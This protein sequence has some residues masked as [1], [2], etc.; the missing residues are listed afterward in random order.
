M[1]YFPS[2]HFSP[3][4]LLLLLC[5]LPTQSW[6]T[7]PFIQPS[8]H[9]AWISFLHFISFSLTVFHKQMSSIWPFQ[10]LCSLSCGIF[11][12]CCISLFTLHQ[13]KFLFP[14]NYCWGS[15]RQF[16]RS[17]NLPR[18]AKN[19][20]WASLSQAFRSVVD[21][22]NVYIVLKPRLTAEAALW[23]AH[24]YNKYLETWVSISD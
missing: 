6:L 1:T 2:L 22:Q 18:Q 15:L 24:L 3:T 5:S 21:I 23:S 19:T 16:N 8:W 14:F 17:Y 7:A 10:N 12:H 11:F 9:I 4:Q 20:L 13:Q